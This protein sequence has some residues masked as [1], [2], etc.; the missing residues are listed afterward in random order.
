MSPKSKVQSPKSKARRGG[1]A[2]GVGLWT[3]KAVFAPDFDEA[4]ALAVVVAEDMN[5]VVL[6]KP[7]V[8]LGEEF[9]ALGLGHLRLRGAVGERAEGI[10]AGEVQGGS[11]KSKAQPAATARQRGESPK[12]RTSPGRLGFQ[13]GGEPAIVA[14]RGQA[15]GQGARRFGTGLSG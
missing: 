14:L 13:F 3:F 12:S 4:L 7:A 6:A 2:L 10:E 1:R 5:T 9:A 8:E 15:C 11:P